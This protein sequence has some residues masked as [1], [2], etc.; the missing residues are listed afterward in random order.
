MTFQQ[1]HSFKIFVP[2]KRGWLKYSQ[3]WA[4]DSQAWLCNFEGQDGTVLAKTAVLAPE[5]AQEIW[6]R[7]CAAD[8]CE[9]KRY[10][11]PG[12]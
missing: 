6:E 3:S 1:V 10:Q 4:T 9:T 7:F 5:Q 8:T 11:Y 2:E 12:L